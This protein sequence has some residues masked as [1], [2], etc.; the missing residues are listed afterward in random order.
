M[1][2]YRKHKWRTTKKVIAVII[3]I[4]LAVAL[5]ALIILLFL[6]PFI[7]TN[8][9]LPTTIDTA[10]VESEIFELINEERCD[11]GLPKLNIDTNLKTIAKG[12]CDNLIEIGEL[13][14]GNFE[15][16]IASIDYQ[17]YLCGEIIA[18]QNG[19]SL[20][21]AQDFVDG[22]INSPEHYDI[23]MIESN[24]YM[25]VGVSKDGSAFYAVVDFRFM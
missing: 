11:H 16:R 24:G 18:Y 2:H 12:W 15:Q 14:H 4:I 13:T 7:L 25:G 9:I 3:G 5:I 23:M 19:W 17:Y 21:L 6:S 10:Q 1:R 22:W 8:V 20:S